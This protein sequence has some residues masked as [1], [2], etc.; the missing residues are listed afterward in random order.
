MKKI[1][2]ILSIFCFF[3]ISF[4]NTIDPMNLPKF[5]YFIND[6]SQVLT[7]EQTQ[8]LNQYAENI[9]SNLGYQV[10]SVLFP[11]R[12]GN[13]LFDIALKAFNENEIGDKQRNDG[14][15]LAIATEEK[16]IRIM[17]WY[18]LEG[19]IPDLLASQIIEEKIR[20]EVN[21]WNIYQGIKNFYEVING[22]QSLPEISQEEWSDWIY[23]VI[24]WI[25][26][27][28][29]IVL[30]VIFDWGLGFWGWSSG[31]G[32]WFSG[33]GWSSGG[34]WWFSGGGWSSGGGWAG[35]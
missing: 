28:A 33:G 19:K 27:F 17:V 12:Q 29:L 15:L 23:T 34:G 4:A 24:M 11:H 32:W 5:E 21:Q 2:F 35:D 14:L 6:Y 3:G 1:W 7:Q 10:V 25:I 18:G 13:E 31:G 30:Y 16:K 22:K 26:I 8:E 20:P 9:E